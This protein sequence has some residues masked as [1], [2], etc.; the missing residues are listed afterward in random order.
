MLGEP[1]ALSGRY[2]VA[3][4][5]FVRD[6][7]GSERTNIGIEFSL[8][9]IVKAF[10]NTKVYWKEEPPI[11]NPEHSVNPV[12]A[13]RYVVVHLRGAEPAGQ[14]TKD[15]YWTLAAV[16]PVEFMEKLRT[17]VANG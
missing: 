2:R 14:F 9:D 3:T 10:P 12:S 4:V 7:S 11:F 16:S 5:Y 13:Y 17:A 8:A 6:G 1:D 15:G